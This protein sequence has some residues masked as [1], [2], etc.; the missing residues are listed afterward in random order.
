MT[1]EGVPF[2]LAMLAVNG[3][4][5]AAIGLKGEAIGHALA[6]LQDYCVADG[7]SNAREPL[8]ARAKRDFAAPLC[9]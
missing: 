4:D 3:R 8:L 6:A 5:M 1:A 7:R 2:T 9:E